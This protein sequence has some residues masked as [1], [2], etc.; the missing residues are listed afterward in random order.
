MEEETKE[1]FW[2]MTTSIQNSIHKYRWTWKAAAPDFLMVIFLIPM[3]ALITGLSI[4]LIRL[5]LDLE[6]VV[7]IIFSLCFGPFI[8]FFSISFFVL[9]YLPFGRHHFNYLEISE[10]GVE[11][12]YW[13]SYRVRCGWNDIEK[14]VSHRM[15]FITSDV[16]YLDK[17][18]LFSNPAISAFYNISRLSSKKTITLSGFSGWPNGELANDLRKY[19]PQLF[20][21]EN[22]SA[23]N[24]K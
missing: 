2:K 24:G 17:A 18:E 14:L 11:Y 5:M 22:S 6:I 4:Y 13:P 7:G 20:E 19:A 12:R 3:I 16:L 21:K 1:T 9:A 10:H 8:I 15:I 23:V